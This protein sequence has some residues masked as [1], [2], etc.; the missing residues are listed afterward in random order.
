[1]KFSE[2]LNDLLLSSYPIVGEGA[3]VGEKSNWGLLQH[4]EN[5]RDVHTFSG[6]G[7]S[8]RKSEVLSTNK[9]SSLTDIKI[10][11]ILAL[12]YKG[13]FFVLISHAHCIGQVLATVQP[14]I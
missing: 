7:T 9:E 14:N 13:T 2:H 1:V 10:L 5:S 12:I 6:H 8:L 3:S 11:C 4:S